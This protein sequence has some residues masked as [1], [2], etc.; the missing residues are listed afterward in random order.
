MMLREDYSRKA[1]M[2]VRD[3][4][5]AA[6]KRHIAALRFRG[7]DDT[8]R[9]A[10]VDDDWPTYNDRQV[11]PSACVDPGAWRYAPW[12]MTPHLLED[13][14]EPKGMP[15]WGL[16]K[17]AE[18]EADFVLACRTNLPAE[19]KVLIHSIEDAFETPRLLM[20]QHGARYGILLPLPDYYGLLGRFTLTGGQILDTED[21]AARSQKDALFTISVQASKVQVGPVFPMSINIRKQLGGPDAPVD[22]LTV[23]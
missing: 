21:K 20:D 17:V 11:V 23:S 16:Y 1:T 9:F 13:T 6:L 19:R 7:S 2:D 10:V 18:I 14:W 4:L 15:G 3:A 8:D 22:P 5:A 12:S